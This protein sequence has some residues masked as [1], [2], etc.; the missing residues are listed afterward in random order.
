VHDALTGKVVRQLQGADPPGG[1]HWEIDRDV[2]RMAFSPDGTTLAVA[3]LGQLYCARSEIDGMLLALI[4]EPLS[5]P[6]VLWD[7]RTGKRLRPID[8]GK[9]VVSR[10][11]F[12]PDGRTLATLNQEN[13]ITLW[14][15]ATGKER[16]SFPSQGGHT[17]VAFTPDGRT[18]LAAGGASPVI[19]AYSVVTGNVVAQIKGHGGPITALAVKGNVLVSASTDTTALVWD[20]AGLN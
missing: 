8:T 5:K 12:S 16:L 15:M 1:P 9:H 2:G 3:A 20:P 10:L 13:T 14:E 7:V 19:H 4:Y 17:V 11:V 18:L 6:I